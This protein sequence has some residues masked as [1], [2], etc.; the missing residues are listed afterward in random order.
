[1]NGGYQKN[2]II[3]WDEAAGTL[4][5]QKSTGYPMF[6]GL[7]YKAIG[8]FHTQAEVDKYPHWN[9]ARPGDVIFEDYNQDGK[10]DSKDRVRIYKSDVPRFTGGLTFNGQ[11]KGFDLSLLFQGAAGA[12][13]YI[14]TE[15]GE[16]GNFL[17]SFAE[18]RWTVNNPDASGPRTFNRGN[19]YWVGQGNTYW[20][21]KTNYIRLKNVELGYNLPASLIGK[22]GIQNVRIYVNAYNFLTWAPDLKEF[23]PE[24]GANNANSNATNNSISTSGQGYPLQKILNA[25]ISVTF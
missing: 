25:G 9:G 6:S 10:I 2:R 7:Y 17:Q 23:D 12:V 1:L 3:F 21:H 19:E 4:D 11:F 15:S 24:F 5:Y 20:L 14:S 16:I 8:I 22:A 13:R 18:N